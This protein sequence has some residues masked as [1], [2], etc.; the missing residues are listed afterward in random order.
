MLEGQRD[1]LVRA[2][3]Q[4]RE[5]GEATS[6][7]PALKLA[8]DRIEEIHRLESDELGTLPSTSPDSP[9]SMVELG[10]SSTAQSFRQQLDQPFSSIQHTTTAHITPSRN[11]AEFDIV[12]GAVPSEIG[13]VVLDSSL[14]AF[15]MDE[16]VNDFAM[17]SNPQVPSH[18]P[19]GMQ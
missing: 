12:T 4:L 11:E 5:S 17:H 15:T 16:W 10:K 18:I 2:I 7:D 14:T 1:T 13:P 19:S 6:L 9:I 8:V 3:R